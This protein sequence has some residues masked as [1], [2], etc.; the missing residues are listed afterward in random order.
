MSQIISSARAQKLVAR[1]A[2]L[3]DV[4]SPVDYAVSSLPQSVNIP[5]RNVSKMMS[6]NKKTP[7]VFYG[8]TDEDTDMKQA[9]NYAIQ[10]GFEKVY[11]LGSMK[12]W[13]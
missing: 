6:L 5:L 9:E 3:I 2:K 1:G 7:L 13:E 11:I 10:M 8:N 4:R 12:N